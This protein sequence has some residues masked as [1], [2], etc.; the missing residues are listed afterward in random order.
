MIVRCNLKSNILQL[1]LIKISNWF[2]L[3]M[4][5]VVVFYSSNGLNLKDLLILQAIYSI[6]IV[7]LEIPSGYMADAIGRRITIMLGCI[8][9]V[10]GFVIYSFTSG[11]WPFMLAEITLGIGSSFISGADSAILYDSLLQLKQENEYTKYE[12]RITSAGNFS[13]AIAAILGGLLAKYISIRAPYFFQTG[14]AALG[15]PASIMLLEPSK[16]GALIK[17]HFAD[18]LKVVRYSLID[19][20]LLRRNIFFSSVIGASTLTMAWFVQPYFLQI[21][22]PLAMYGILWTSLNLTAAV[23]A[24]I[25]YRIEKKLGDTRTMILITVGISLG[26]FAVGMFQA[27]WALLFFYLFYFIR[28]VATPVL[29]DYINRLTASEVRATVLSVRSFIIR[30]LFSIIGPFLGWYS[31]KF[32]LSAAF[33]FA[34]FTFLILGSATLILYLIGIRTERKAIQ[35]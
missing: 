29:K 13:E 31:G 35:Q 15:I 9:G 11:F 19:N 22:I 14:I 20:K 10:V 23:T 16:Q 34:G 6:S 30:I 33:Y 1:Y 26:Y 24:I 3:Y 5:I 32:S 4:P 12:G 7:A 18:I 21:N 8:L 2:M 27:L 28:G 25:A 17:Y